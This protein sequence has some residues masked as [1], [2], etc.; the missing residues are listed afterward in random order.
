MANFVE[1]GHEI[2]NLATLRPS[3]RV[4]CAQI[5][6]T[7]AIARNSNIT[8]HNPNTMNTPKYFFLELRSILRMF[9]NSFVN[10]GPNNSGH[11]RFV[12]VVWVIQKYDLVTGIV[13]NATMCT[14]SDGHRAQNLT[15]NCKSVS[16][17]CVGYKK[18]P[19]SSLQTKGHLLQ[20]QF[21]Y[22]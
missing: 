18:L 8:K 13:R 15:L 16:F 2:A 21:T 7:K 9:S 4:D 20:N 1:F 12:N 19:R 17:L 10:C 5:M 6:T 11:H 14:Q 22:W 3:T